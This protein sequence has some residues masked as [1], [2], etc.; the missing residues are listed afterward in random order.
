MVQQLTSPPVRKGPN[1][2][3]TGGSVVGSIGRAFSPLVPGSTGT[4]G[5]RPRLVWCGPLA[6]GGLGGVGLV[7]QGLTSPPVR[8]G[9]DE[10]GT[11]LSWC[12]GLGSGWTREGAAEAAP[13]EV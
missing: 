11:R 8:K 12:L 2:L 10:W 3:G 5:L 6:L 7:V 13:F 4:W 1:E 9:A